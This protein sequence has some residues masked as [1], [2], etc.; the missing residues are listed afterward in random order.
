MKLLILKENLKKGLEITERIVSKNLTLLILNNILLS[1]EKNSL[2][3][4]ATDLEIGINFWLLA[5]IEKEGQITIPAKFLSGI[6]NYLPGDKIS[7]EVKNQNLIIEDKDN[8]T[9]IKGTSS[10]DFP[11]IPSIEKNNFININ[12]YLFSQ[13]L[14]QV[15]E[16]CSITQTRPE[17]SGVFIVFNKNFITF[18]ATDSFRLSE[19]KIISQI[20]TSSLFTPTSL[21]LPQK[22][23]RELINILSDKKE[24]L[25]VYFSP[26]QIM[27][28]LKNK[29]SDQPYIQIISRLIEGEYPNYQEIIPKKHGTEIY[30][31]K[32]DFLNQI[33]LASLFGGKINEVR[34]DIDPKKKGLNIFAQ[35]PDWGET[36]SFISGEVKGEKTSVSFNWKFLIDGLNNI[37]SQ[38]VVFGLNK[39]DGP[40]TLKPV[41]DETYVYVVMPIKSS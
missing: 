7:L 33:K 21:I 4:S 11:I 17:I 38:E 26:N 40:A 34:F 23:A 27:F 29:E 31:K 10:K 5:K 19:K 24:E 15:V 32:N 6:I 3:I 35:S 13:G 12:A 14:N 1:T 16:N 36:N 28:E 25:C 30:L 9:Q 41:G 37:K 22:T 18:A 39:E 2:K 20:K 8:K